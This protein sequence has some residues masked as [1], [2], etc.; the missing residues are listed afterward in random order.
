VTLRLQ[1]YLPSLRQ[2]RFVSLRRRFA[3]ASRE[4]FRIVHFSVQATHIH[5]V[6]EADDKLALARG[7]QGLAV[8]LARAVNRLLRRRGRVF[9]E[10]Y[11]A[12]PL[13]SPRAVRN[14]IV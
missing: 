11:H 1:P 4:W 10:R 3:R 13:T 12:R 8:R 6:V 2:P 14:A 5:L 9:A 7:V